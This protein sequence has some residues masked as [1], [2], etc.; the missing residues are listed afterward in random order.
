MDPNLTYP[1]II[2]PILNATLNA[3]LYQPTQTGLNDWLKANFL[4]IVQ[5]IMAAA[6]AYLTYELWRTTS[7]YADQV[8]T[9]TGIMTKNAELSERTL[10]I[11]EKNR[12]REQLI[13]EMDKLVGPLYS[14]INDKG[15]FNPRGIDGTRYWD[16]SLTGEIDKKLY[17]EGV[18]WQEISQYKYLATYELQH[19]IDRY[20]EIKLNSAMMGKWDDPKYIEPEKNLTDA[21]RT[22]YGEI[23]RE[24]S[25]IESDVRR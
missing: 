2:T 16:N 14:R 7:R 17:E 10:E 6:L 15:I 25:R 3:T 4:G 20:L 19:K 11:G 9:Q 8:E 24:L 21:V 5:I 13:K 18:F 23:E 1:I 12:R 22:R